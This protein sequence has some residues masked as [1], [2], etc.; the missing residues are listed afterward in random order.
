MRTGKNIGDDFREPKLTLPV[1]KRR[2]PKSDARKSAA[3]WARTIEKG[4][5]EGKG[6]SGPRPVAAAQTWHAKNETK[7]EALRGKK[8]KTAIDTAA[9]SRP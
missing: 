4:R 5:Q 1:I 7:S 2:L 3:F 6:D 8:A 9:R